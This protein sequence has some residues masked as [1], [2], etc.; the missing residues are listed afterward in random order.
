MHVATVAHFCM[1]HHANI[2][3]ILG[4]VKKHILVRGKNAVLV[5]G[6]MPSVHVNGDELG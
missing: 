3:A 5:S 1:E 4:E 2:W 6:V